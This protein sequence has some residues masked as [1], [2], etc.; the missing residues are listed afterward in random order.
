V[1]R[2]AAASAGRST[3]RPGCRWGRE[4]LQVK[5]ATLAEWRKLGKGPP[6]LRSEPA[7]TKATI[8]YR[9]ADVEAWEESRIVRPG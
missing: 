5:A 8:R 6:Y 9:L 7:G 2:A 3:H 1:N 4:R